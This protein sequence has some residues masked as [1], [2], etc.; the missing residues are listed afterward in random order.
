M[1]CEIM[2]I[3]A[4]IINPPQSWFYFRGPSNQSREFAKTTVRKAKD[5][6]TIIFII[7][8]IINI[9]SIITY[10]NKIFKFLK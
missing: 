1:I 10:L 3:I 9:V 8:H 7:L 5:C 6:H 4:F 2:L